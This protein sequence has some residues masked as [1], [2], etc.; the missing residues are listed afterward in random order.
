[1]GAN[2]GQDGMRRA[3]K[4]YNP[5]EEAEKSAYFFQDGMKRMLCVPSR[6]LYACIRNSASYFKTKGRNLKPI[7][8]GA[9]RVE[10][11]NISLGTDKYEIDTQSVVIQKAR[12]L[13]SRAKLPNWK[14]NFK[15]IFNEDYIA[16]ADI[17]RKILE[18]AGVKVGL[19]DYRP[20]K[21]GNF[22][23]FSVTKFELQE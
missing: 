22:G 15:L 14:L 4:S 17:L 9:V 6:C 8:A 13:K 2:L 10:P 19:L 7:I 11:E 5:A 1:M 20:Q 3:M 23:T 18:E 16:D 21:S 12:V